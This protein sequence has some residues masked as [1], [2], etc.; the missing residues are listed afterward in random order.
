MQK[1]TIYTCELSGN[2]IIDK[3]TRTQCQKCRFDKCL[4][5]GM[6]PHS[7]IKHSQVN[8]DAISDTFSFTLSAVLSEKLKTAKRPQRDVNRSVRQKA[9][10][11][12]QLFVAEKQQHVIYKP[13]P[14]PN[15][16]ADQ[17]LQAYRAAFTR[18]DFSTSTAAPPPDLLDE[19]GSMTAIYVAD[20]LTPSIGL[21]I[22]FAKVLPGF[23]TVEF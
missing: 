12:Q 8:F 13:V 18:V 1:K 23:S 3:L 14:Y 10:Q 15:D 21:V 19:F 20:M 22:Q 5:V 4:A 11:Q 9:G 17:I 2:C 6:I 7:G 16:P